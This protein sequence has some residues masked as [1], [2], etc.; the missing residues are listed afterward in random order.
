[1][2]ASSLAQPVKKD[3]TELTDAVSQEYLRL[4]PAG[5]T[6]AKNPRNSIATANVYVHMASG[7]TE[8][9]AASFL[10]A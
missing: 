8:Q 7:Q 3:T 10:H 6:N 5:V 2:P 4:A 1:M 9:T